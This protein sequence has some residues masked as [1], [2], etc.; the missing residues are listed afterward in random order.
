MGTQGVDGD[1]TDL[2]VGDT[3]VAG[4]CRMAFIGLGAEFQ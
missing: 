3:G 1:G 4:T 2:F